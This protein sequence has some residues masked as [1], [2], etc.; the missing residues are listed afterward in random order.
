MPDGGMG[1]L[2][3]AVAFILLGILLAGTIAV[4]NDAARTGSIARSV[5]ALLGG[6]GSEHGEGKDSDDGR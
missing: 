2:R 6:S 3:R 1:M 4:A 5:T